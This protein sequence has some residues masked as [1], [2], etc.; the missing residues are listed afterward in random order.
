[1]GESGFMGLRGFPTPTP[2]VINHW[3][4]FLEL[5]IFIS[6]L[7]TSDPS[8]TTSGQL[9]TGVVD[10]TMLYIVELRILSRTF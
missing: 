9:V 6:Y 5:N 3:I 7:T 1:M 2:S 10:P 8:L 4:Q